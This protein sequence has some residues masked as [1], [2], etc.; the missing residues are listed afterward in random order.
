MLARACERLGWAD[1]AWTFFEKAATAATDATTRDLAKQGKDAVGRPP[2]GLDLQFLAAGAVDPL[3]L[4]RARIEARDGETALSWLF[5]QDAI[6]FDRLAEIVLAGHAIPPARPPQD[7]L[8][9]RLLSERKITQGDLKQALG[10]QAATHRPLGTL[11]IEDFGLAPAAMQAALGA[12]SALQPPLGPADDPAILLIRWGALR[13]EHWEAVKAQGNRAFETLVARQQVLAANVRRAEAF[14]MTKQ[15]LMR[16]GRFRLGESLVASAVIDREILAKALAWQV[17]Q[18]SRLGELLIRH[19]LASVEQVLDGLLA[20]ARRYDETAESLLP[21]VERPP[22]APPEIPAANRPPSRR[23]FALVGLAGLSLL[24]ALVMANRYTR[25]DFAWL[26]SFVKDPEA[27]PLA[28]RGMAELLGGTQSSG[29]RRERGTAFDPLNLPDSE[30]SGQPMTE[31]QGSTNWGETTGEGFI[32]KRLDEGFV[33]EETAVERNGVPMGDRLGAEPVSRFSDGKPVGSSGIKDSV[34]YD[35]LG[36]SPLAQRATSRQSELQ[37][38]NAISL[39]VQAERLPAGA[40]AVREGGSMRAAE[41]ADGKLQAPISL[42]Q[43]IDG[44]PP[45]TIQV[46]RDTAIFRLRLGRS[47]FERNDLAS[48]REEFLSAIALDPT[49]SPPH[50]YLGRIAEQRGDA[51][52]AAKW[53][54]TYGLRSPGGEHSADVQDRLDR[55]GN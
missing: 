17:D 24:G 28:V 51:E 4:A 26:G 16:E 45:E 41:H 10:K 47:L 7:R 18:P 42:H 34:A 52:L 44:A 19:R 22:P 50:Y 49:L 15:K 23:K 3:D 14:R 55:L 5:R 27:S 36:S 11:L 46:R 32:G 31:V 21:P 9:M 25:G 12:Q 40:P 54:G 43:S 37:T 35:K 29:P 38:L 33:G 13:R 2:P 8:G 20:Q 39:P 48:A 30:L 53:Y 1:L 6:S